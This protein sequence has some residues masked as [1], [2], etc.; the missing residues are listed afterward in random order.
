MILCKTDTIQ[1]IIEKETVQLIGYDSILIDND[2]FF[3]KVK[4]IGKIDFLIQLKEDTLLRFESNPI[5][6][7]TKTRFQTRMEE[8]T[9]RVES[10][11]ES[12]VKIVESKQDSKTSRTAIRNENNNNT[13]SISDK[14]RWFINGLCAGILVF[15]ILFAVFVKNRN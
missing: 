12:K 14:F 8:K 4:A 15:G 7:P 13:G 11:N 10:K 9:R 3:L 5:L 2:R 1:K 6:V